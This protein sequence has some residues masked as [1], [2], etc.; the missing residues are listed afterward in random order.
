MINLHWS[1][2]FTRNISPDAWAITRLAEASRP[3]AETGQGFV[4]AIDEIVKLKMHGSDRSA[5]FGSC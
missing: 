4:I 5:F 1:L 2:E 3:N